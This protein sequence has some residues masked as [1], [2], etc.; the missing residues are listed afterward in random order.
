MSNYVET[1][2]YM[3]DLIWSGSESLES[4]NKHER[5]KLISLFLSEVPKKELPIFEISEPGLS[6]MSNFLI[7]PDS[8]FKYEL[9]DEITD[10]VIHNQ[11]SKLESLFERMYDKYLS[12]KGV[13]SDEDD[14]LSQ[15]N[16]SRADDMNAAIFAGL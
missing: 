10:T 5:C 4:L 7:S 11:R 3:Y 8:K 1:Q 14:F 13:L 15:D 12:Q 16:K 6:I 2:A 9:V